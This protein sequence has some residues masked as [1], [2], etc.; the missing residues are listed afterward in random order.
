MCARPLLNLCNYVSTSSVRVKT[1]IQ[2]LVIQFVETNR[3]LCFHE[4]NDKLL[5]APLYVFLPLDPVRD[6]G[7]A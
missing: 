6:A 7:Y 5:A 4:L 2:Q 1:H 3:P